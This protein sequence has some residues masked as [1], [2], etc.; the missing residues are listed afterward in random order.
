MIAPP[1]ALATRA[2]PITSKLTLRGPAV[3]PPPVSTPPTGGASVVDGVV[4][5]GVIGVVVVVVVGVICC[6]QAAW[7]MVLVS[8]VTAPFRANARPS[9]EAPVV[10]VMEVNARMFPLKTVPVPR[11]AELPTCQKTLHALAPLM[12]FTTLA[13]AVTSVLAIWNTKTALGSP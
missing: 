11:V 4:G 3:D 7:V 10:R 9:I 5:T 1:T 12:T 13:E 2:P 8:I 6:V